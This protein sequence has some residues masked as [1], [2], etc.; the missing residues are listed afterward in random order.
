MATLLQGSN[1]L[2]VNTVEGLDRVLAQW[3][4]GAAVDAALL[5][6][7]AMLDDAGKALDVEVHSAV[8]LRRH[9]IDRGCND[10]AREVSD[11]NVARRVRAHPRGLARRVRPED[12]AGRVLLLGPAG[13]QRVRG[14]RRGRRRPRRCRRRGGRPQ[15]WERT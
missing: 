12:A 2:F 6:H 7:E 13:R 8:G 15:R 14:R 5:E 3:D 9:L 4:F 11:D 10:L 1:K